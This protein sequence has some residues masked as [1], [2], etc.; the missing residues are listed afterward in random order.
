MGRFIDRVGTK[1][2]YAVSLIVWSL[3][4]IGHGFVKSTVGFFIARST[5]GISEAEIFGSHIKSVL[6]GFRKKKEPCN[7]IFNSGA[8]VSYFST[9]SCSFHLGI[10]AGEKLLSGL[11]HWVYYGLFCGGDFTIFR[12]N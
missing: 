1:I 6:N 5:L 11:A 2:G 4:S 3:A 7:G 10:M 12:K 9:A 8:T